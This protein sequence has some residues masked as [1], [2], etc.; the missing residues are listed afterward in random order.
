MSSSAADDSDDDRRSLAAARGAGLI[1]IADDTPDTRELYSL[2]LTHRGFDVLTA[3]DGHTAID[4][5]RRHQPDLVIMDL[6]MPRLDGVAATNR[7]KRDAR[8]RRT[9]VIVLTAHAAKEMQQR[10]LEAGASALLM[11]PC[12]PEDL[13][14]HVQRLIARPAP[15]PQ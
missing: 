2:Y 12:L 7:L 3:Q 10:A 4:L 13:E 6:S 8:T 11:K 9:P 5:A 15:R 1:L 14:Q